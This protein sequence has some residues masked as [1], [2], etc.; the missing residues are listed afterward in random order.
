MKRLGHHQRHEEIPMSAKRHSFSRAQLD[1]PPLI[2]ENDI[3]K[4]CCPQS[5]KASGWPFLETYTAGRF[6]FQP[7]D[8]LEQ[9]SQ[10]FFQGLVFS[11][12]VELAYK[13]TAAFEHV[14]TEL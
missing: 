1:R 11:S 12:L 5:Q 4:P 10:L 6:W 14:E 3:C 13:M 7:V 8:L 2:P 9:G